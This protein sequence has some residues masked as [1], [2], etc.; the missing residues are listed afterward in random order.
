MMPETTRL[1]WP[2][3]GH[4]LEL[5]ALGL[6]IWCWTEVRSRGGALQHELLIAVLYGWLLEALDMWIFGSYHYG[7]VTWWWVG[8]VPLYIPLL[9]AIIL[10][11]SMVL[12]DRVG[13][14]PWARPFLD[15]LLAVLM[16]LAIDAV[17]IRVG[18]WHWNIRLDEGWFGV[19]AGN[20]C[21]WMWVA[22]WY[23]GLTRL[24]RG[25]IRHRGEPRWHY[26]LIPPL[27]FAGLFMSLS[28]TGLIGH[29]VG[30]DTPTE[31]LWLFA[32][33]LLLFLLVV[34]YARLRLQRAPDAG[35]IPV[36]FSSARWI[37][38]GSFCLIL[39]FSAVWR[40][41]PVLAA[42]SGVALIVEWWAQSLCEHENRARRSCFMLS[43][44]FDP[45]RGR[46]VS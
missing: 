28:L 15:G 14:A 23:G 40:Q 36:S 1:A 4:G 27:A 18:L 42:I 32:I 17:A 41:V 6:F 12:S 8:H 5:G 2:W 9:W 11:S 30:L 37:M 22:T 34:G 33:Q 38:H 19:P 43:K 10:H 26:G 45:L 39:W 35:R 13:L 44:A 24:V 16:D 46:A 25:R 3:L 20:L 21:A 7:S 31:R 29:W